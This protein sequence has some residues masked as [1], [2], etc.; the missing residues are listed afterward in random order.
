LNIKRERTKEKEIKEEKDNQLEDIHDFANYNYEFISN[1]LDLK[2]FKNIMHEKLAQRSNN[3][4]KFIIFKSLHDILFLI[5]ATSSD[6]IVCY[7][8]N[9]NKKIN[10]IKKAHKY[11]IFDFQHFLDKKNERDLLLT[12]PCWIYD[13]KLWDIN[14]LECIYNFK[15]NYFTDEFYSEFYSDAFLYT[16]CFLNNFDNNYIIIGRSFLLMSEMEFPIEVYDF[17][18]NLI[19]KIKDS[20]EGSDKIICYYDEILSKQFIISS[21]DNYVK[22]FYFDENKIYHKYFEKPIKVNDDDS[23]ISDKKIDNENNIIIYK[24]DHMINLIDLYN[25]GIVR[26]WNFH[27]AELLRKIDITGI[28]SICLWNNKYLFMGC[29]DNSIKLIELK[30]GNIIKSFLRHEDIVNNIRKMVHPRYGECLVTQGTY[31]FDINL[32]IL[33]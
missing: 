19:K 5:Y 17:N 33:S 14:K 15:G 7:D 32:W 22:S 6:S 18:G 21:Y 27:S 30:K 9:E 25:E 12:I 1:P 26:I 23:E 8:I 3:K 31:E 24:E 10:E 2:F 13:I 4:N 16:A 20:I 28:Y 29:G 11:N